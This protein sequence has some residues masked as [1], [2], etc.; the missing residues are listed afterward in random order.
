MEEGLCPYKEHS[1][2][3]AKDRRNEKLLEIGA[4]EEPTQVTESSSLAENIQWRFLRAYQ[5]VKSLSCR[6]V[7]QE[8]LKQ[9]ADSQL[10]HGCKMFLFSSLDALVLPF[11]ES[12]RL[13]FYL[14]SPKVWIAS[15]GLQVQKGFV[16]KLRRTGSDNKVLLKRSWTS[17]GC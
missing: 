8:V 16:A 17:C 5:R 12:T 15:L 11:R 3:G 14:A 2:P 9:K 13:S 10:Q 7:L 4:H 1:Y 6:V